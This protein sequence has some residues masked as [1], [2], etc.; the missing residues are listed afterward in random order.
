MKPNAK[1]LTRSGELVHAFI[2]LPFQLMPEVAMWGSRIF[3][4]KR[5]FDQKFGQPCEPVYYE[6]CAWHVAASDYFASTMPRDSEIIVNGKKHQ[7]CVHELWYADI[8]ELAGHPRD[9]HLSVT[10]SR[11]HNNEGGCLSFGQSVEIKGGEV[12]NAMDTGSA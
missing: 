8:L 3:V 5:P 10:W 11:R 6:A 4:L 12:F 2:M 7:V 9:R 1:L